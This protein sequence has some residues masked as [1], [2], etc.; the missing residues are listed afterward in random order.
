MET[1]YKVFRR[2]ALAGIRLRAVGFDFEPEITAKLLRAKRRIHE[3]P[4]TYRPRGQDEGKKISWPDG[5]DAIYMLIK[6][7]LY[8]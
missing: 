1:G 6:C 4:V 2:E 3:V 5:L 8:P 7:R